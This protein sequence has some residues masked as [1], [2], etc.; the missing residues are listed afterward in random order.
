MTFSITIP[1]RIGQALSD[2]AQR[3]FDMQPTDY[4]KNALFAAAHNKE[5]FVLRLT[6]PPLKPDA[7]QFELPLGG[8]KATAE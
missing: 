5:G 1:D 4:L 3:S 6:L 2:E 7:N 8:G